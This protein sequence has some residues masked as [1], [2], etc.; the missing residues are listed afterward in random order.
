M[1]TVSG[2]YGSSKYA[3]F[4]AKICSLGLGSVTQEHHEMLLKMCISFWEKCTVVIKR[5]L[6]LWKLWLNFSLV[7]FS[8]S[9]WGNYLIQPGQKTLSHYYR[10]NLIYKS[11]AVNFLFLSTVCMRSLAYLCIPRKCEYSLWVRYILRSY[12]NVIQ[13]ANYKCKFMHDPHDWKF[14]WWYE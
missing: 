9:V 7:N 1:S 4:P 8:L 2:V 10:E 5:N 12:S 11:R 6:T 3:Q 14:Y 13:M